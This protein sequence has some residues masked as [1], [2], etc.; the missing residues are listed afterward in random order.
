[1]GIKISLILFLFTTQLFSQS[2]DEILRD[3]REE[4]VP[5]KD[6][7]S[8][9]K[10]FYLEKLRTIYLAMGSALETKDDKRAIDEGNKLEKEG[11]APP[12]VIKIRGKAEL[13]EEQVLY[14]KIR[15]LRAEAYY[16]LREFK[17]A[18]PDS[19]FI[20]ENHPR[21]VV[22]DFTRY[23]VSLYYSGDEKT[24]KKILEQANTKFKNENDQVILSKTI[25]LLFNGY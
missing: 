9:P 17:S 8:Y 25:K 2:Q 24:C 20:V 5:F 1:M 21:P 3:L 10:D 19:K 15:K 18:L 7:E 13:G 16:N 4:N 11:I 14:L 22:F 6:K 12:G 23:A